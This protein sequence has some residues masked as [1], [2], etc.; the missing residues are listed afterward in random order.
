MSRRQVG[1]TATSDSSRVVIVSGLGPAETVISIGS[2]VGSVSTPTRASSLRWRASGMSVP[3]SRL[4]R[5]GR[6]ATRDGPG[7]SGAVSTRPAATVPPAHSAI[8]R[9]V[10]SAP[11]R[12][13]RNS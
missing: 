8:S 5:L 9:A 13:S 6:N 4:T 10:R 7:S 12:A 2:P 1:T 3:S 11:S